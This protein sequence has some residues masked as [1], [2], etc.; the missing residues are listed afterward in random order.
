MTQRQHMLPRVCSPLM[1]IINFPN[2]SLSSLYSPPPLPFSSHPSYPF[3]FV[4]FHPTVSSLFFS[5]SFSS[6]F[7][8]PSVPPPH[9]SPSLSSLSSPSTHRHHSLTH[10]LSFVVCLLV[11]LRLL[12][13]PL[14]HL[15]FVRSLHLPGVHRLQHE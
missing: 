1:M 2:P 12:I 8:H 5:F 9:L 6:F 15:L 13:S 11:L 4:S 14:F 7:F 3:T 10:S